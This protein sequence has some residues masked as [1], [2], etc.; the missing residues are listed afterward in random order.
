MNKPLRYFIRVTTAYG[1]RRNQY[2]FL[3]V[4]VRREDSINK[5]SAKSYAVVELD[6]KNLNAEPRAGQIWEVFGYADVKLVERNGY[7]FAQYLFVGSEAK[8]ILPE[9][10]EEFISFIAKEPDFKGIGEAKARKIFEKFG[11]DLF[12]MLNTG[13]VEQIEKCFTPLIAESLVDGYRK[14]ENLQHAMYLAKMGVPPSVQ[15]KLFKYH[16]SDAIAQIKDNPYIL[17]HFGMSFKEVDNLAIK[18]FDMDDYDKRRMNAIVECAMREYCKEGHTVT[19]IDNLWNLVMGITKNDE[20][21]AEECIVN[22]HSSLAIYF[23][24]NT[25][26]IHHTALFVMESVI[27]KRIRYLIDQGSGWCVGGDEAYSKAV[28]QFQFPLTEKQG[29]AIIESL[30]HH[31]F[32]LTGGAGTGKTT[33]MKAVVDAHLS[34]DFKVYAVALSGRAAKRL[35]ESIEIETQT[36]QRFL[37]IDDEDICCHDSILLV[38]DESSMVDVPSLYKIVMKLPK[39]ARIIFAG[40]EEQLPPIGSGLV[41]SEIIKSGVVPRTHLDVVRRQSGETGIPVY[42]NE[43]REGVVPENLTYKN[44]KFINANSANIVSDIVDLYLSLCGEVQIISPTRKIAKEVNDLCQ[45]VANPYGK[46]LLLINATGE[47]E[48]VGIRLGDPV[49]FTKNNYEVDIQNGTLGKV[50]GLQDKED[51]SILA[52]VEIDTG[53]VVDIDYQLLDD[54]ELSY[55]ITLHKAQGSQFETVIAP[56][57]INRLMDKSWVY[58]CITRAT[59]N[60]YWLGSEK[61]LKKAIVSETKASQRNVCLSVL[62]EDSVHAKHELSLS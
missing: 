48:D 62:L 42:A 36:I 47:T 9:T 29:E 32:A 31:V 15:Q 7:E 13:N 5:V 1:L 27:A 23:N 50:V 19:L 44:I 55:A 14:Y 56:V 16:K 52:K 43:I 20:H 11:T 61:V 6:E 54:M 4:F 60:M 21:L 58:T 45:A 53:R 59:K 37:M 17:Q 34:M 24:Q 25:S 40:D 38:I 33:V 57:V 8:M 10:T 12:S 28:S 49:I 2:R 46:K 51:K 30:A 18:S 3:G 41:L 26:Q 22:A 39:Y 35:H